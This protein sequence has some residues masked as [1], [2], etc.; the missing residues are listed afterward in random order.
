MLEEGHVSQVAVGVLPRLQAGAHC[1]PTWGATLWSLLNWLNEHKLWTLCI[2]HVITSSSRVNLFL[3]ELLHLCKYLFVRRSPCSCLANMANSYCLSSIA[4]AGFAFRYTIYFVKSAPEGRGWLYFLAWGIQGLTGLGGGPGVSSCGGGDEELEG[5]GGG[6]PTG[7][8]GGPD[9]SGCGGGNEGVG[10]G[11]PA[12]QDT[13][14]IPSLRQLS[15]LARACANHNHRAQLAQ[16]RCRQLL[17]TSFISLH[18]EDCLATS[19]LVF[20][21]LP[22]KALIYRAENQRQDTHLWAVLEEDFEWI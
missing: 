3:Q 19:L 10:G 16:C 7:L 18:Q 2:V 13:Y 14:G 5:L 12:D 8:G 22:T 4:T 20:R 6:F 11:L 9:V 17:K 15:R 1:W 21:K